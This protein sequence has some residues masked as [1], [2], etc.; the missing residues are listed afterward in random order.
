MLE[1]KTS[2][3]L[4][5]IASAISLHRLWP[6]KRA[7]VD[8]CLNACIRS[9]QNSCSKACLISGV[10]MVLQNYFESL[11]RHSHT[12]RNYSHIE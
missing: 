12:L 1:N 4:K 2:F 8:S 9:A 10:F 3:E 11:A 7:A 6:V 5:K